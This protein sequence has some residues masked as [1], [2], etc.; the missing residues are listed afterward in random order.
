MSDTPIVS[1]DTKQIN[2]LI[3]LVKITGTEL[4]LIDDTNTTMKVTVDTLLGYIR[5]T[6]NSSSGDVGDITTGAG[7][8][9]IPADEDIPAASRKAGTF[10]FNICST[11]EAHIS[12]GLP[13]SITVSSN[14]GLDIIE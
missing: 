14:M 12:S 2:E 4:M 8:I 1:V 7:I 10:Y 13:S 9:T 5:D 6:I 3:E 11:E